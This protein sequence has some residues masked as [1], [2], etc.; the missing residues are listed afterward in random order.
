MNL[1]AL[2]R[3]ALKKN[4][5]HAVA[6]FDQLFPRRGHGGPVLGYPFVNSQEQLEDCVCVLAK[7]NALR[8]AKR[9]RA[10]QPTP[11]TALVPP[12]T[13]TCYHEIGHAVGDFVKWPTTFLQR[14]KSI[15]VSGRYGIV[16][17]IDPEG[18]APLERLIVWRCGAAA[19]GR[20][21][22]TS[23]HL[24][25]LDSW[26]VG[27]AGDVADAKRALGEWFVNSFTSEADDQ[28]ICLIDRHWPLVNFAVSELGKAGGFMS[29][30]R[31][32]EIAMGF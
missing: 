21:Q 23:R 10:K 14:V 4:Y 11:P 13:G 2:C 3:K 30:G 20:F 1:H 8:D 26:S 28:S 29:S 19:Q 24:A 18:A 17:G 9:A 7:A 31:F 27:D 16:R 6:K 5:P 15:E 12:D 25:G 22:L 32:R